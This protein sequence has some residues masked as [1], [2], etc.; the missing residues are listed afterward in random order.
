MQTGHGLRVAA[1]VRTSIFFSC[2]PHACCMSQ[3]GCMNQAMHAY[4]PCLHRAAGR[5]RKANAVIP[6]QSFYK[7]RC[8]IHT[9]THTCTG[10]NFRVEC[11][12]TGSVDVLATM[13]SGGD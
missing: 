9:C 11:D 2:S 12:R 13:H 7:V 1:I 6:A 8:C 4:A 10:E 3:R 5:K